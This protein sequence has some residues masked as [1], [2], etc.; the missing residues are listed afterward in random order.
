MNKFKRV[1][2]RIRWINDMIGNFTPI[3][4]LIMRFMI[5]TM[6]MTVCLIFLGEDKIEIPW[7]LKLIMIFY[8][9]YPFYSHWFNKLFYMIME[10]K[11]LED[12]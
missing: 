12:D 3:F 2:L 5:M 6:I 4:Y 11:D 8:V 10:N 7:L 9:A 1:I